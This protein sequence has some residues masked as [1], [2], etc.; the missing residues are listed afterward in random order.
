MMSL[1][2]DATESV[3]RQ[4]QLAQEALRDPLTGVGNHR[5]LNQDIAML[6]ERE[7][8][9]SLVLL[10]LR[11]LNTINDTLGHSQGDLAL[12]EVASRLQS[13]TQPQEHLYRLNGVEFVL[14]TPAVGDA[15]RERTNALAAKLV[16]TVTMRGQRFR[17]GASFGMVSSPD[18][19]DEADLL[20]RRAATAL[21]SAKRGSGEQ[22]VLFDDS[23]EAAGRQRAA[24]EADF[25]AA[26]QF[27][28][29]SDGLTLALQPK[30]RLKDGHVVGA[31]AL[32][33]WR[34]PERG[35][36]SPADFLPMAQECQLM[37]E[38]DRWVL[39]EALRL[40]RALLNH[41]Y[42]L[43]VS[44]NLSVESLADVQ[45]ARNVSAALLRADVPA[46]LLEVEIPEGALMR[47]VEVS[48]RV[49]AELSALGVRISI[50]DFG[51]GYS[52]FA[53]LAR[54]P[55]STLKIDRSF[56]RD[57][58]SQAASKTIVRSLVSLA[59]ALSLDVVAEGAETEEEMA[60]LRRM[61][62]DVVQG[63]GY[64]RPL[65]FDTF[66]SFVSQRV[67]G[68]TSGRIGEAAPSPFVI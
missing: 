14:L 58:C 24:L 25:R 63:F 2:N 42:Q 11:R 52:S 41:G 46:T 39:D 15:L 13:I 20:L 30:G 49:L 64:G 47:D 60:M 55:V 38:L 50:D 34:H 28:G 33:R 45:L 57:M 3:V 40:Q 66:V 56:V 37:V 68:S 12:M 19:G 9:F 26:L 62:C 51:T 35:P 7:Q 16:E 65:P 29:Q 48:G 10:G 54:F 61:H 8:P 32:I 4:F 67:A 22:P 17:L 23:L 44:I 21:R 59:H 43:P 31:E 18:H 53:Y 36:L 27:H 6:V 5:A 1:A